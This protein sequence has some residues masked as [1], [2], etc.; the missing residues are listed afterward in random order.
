MSKLLVAYWI[1]FYC[2]K[3]ILCIAFEVASALL[4][5]NSANAQPADSSGKVLRHIVIIT[6]KAGAN[7]DSIKRLDNVYMELSKSPIVDDFE[8]G[9]NVS[10]RD[11]GVLKH[12]YVTTFRSKDDMAAYAKGPQFADLFKISLPI[13]EDVTVV[14]YWA[15]K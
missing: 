6:F 11:V 7:A 14:D 8:T 13:A 1:K 2:M 12:V 15:K 4:F 10:T 5:I 9:V 3:K